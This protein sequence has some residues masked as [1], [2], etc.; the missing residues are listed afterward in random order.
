MTD[1]ASILPAAGRDRYSVVAMALHWLTAAVLVIQLALGWR[2]D[3]VEGAARSTILQLHKSVGVTILLLTIARLAWRLVNPPPPHPAGLSRVE[4]RVSRW[5]HRG[6]YASLIVLPLTGWAMA[7]LR[8]A[9]GMTLFG[10]VPWPRFPFLAALSGDTQEAL[11][12]VTGATHT[13]IVWLMLM[14]LAL[15][16]AGALK[17]QFISKDSI[18]SRMAPG[19]TP[20]AAIEARLIAIPLA[21]AALAALVY[22]PR[23]HEATARPKP[24]QLA[25][26]DIYL[27][28]VGPSIARRCGACH[29]DDQARGGLSL[30]SYEGIMQGGRNGLVVAPG[31]P[32]Q[33]ELYRRIRLPADHAKYMPKD[34]KTPLTPAELNAIGFWISQGAPKTAVV[35]SLKLTADAS[36]ALQSIIVGGAEAPADNSGA[37]PQ[38]VLPV[39]AAADPVQVARL[40]AEGVFFIRRVDK[41]SN[42]LDVDFIA[43][44]PLTAEAVAELARIGPQI[45]RLNLRRAGVTDAMVK[46]VAAFP[47]VR[48]LRLEA[49]DI[50]DAAAKDI[51]GMKTLTYVNV[52]NTKMTDKGL[53]DLAQLPRLNR[54][55]IWGDAISPAAV[56]RVKRERKDVILYAGLMAKDVP[57]ETRVATPMN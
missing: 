55:Y 7:S 41:T 40:R 24:A 29:N 19:M 5:A 30:V 50:T 43:N 32:G 39:V 16:I 37:P 3:D 35:S 57:V 36:T 2:L 48:R 10:V 25:K 1:S 17:H 14:L 44:K 47:N 53:G 56:D 12:G 13:V 52:V 31:K 45:F 49:N 42:L 27:D 38:P 4:D 20:G 33:S 22:L 46:T 26:A 28:V 6:F 11:S 9:G 18:V 8:R 51:S 34:G 15:H 54:M 23:I 21:A